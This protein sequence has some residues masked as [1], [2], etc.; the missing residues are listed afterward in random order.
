MT[1]VGSCAGPTQVIGCQEGNPG[2]DY[3]MTTDEPSFG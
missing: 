1:S 2:Y 3:T